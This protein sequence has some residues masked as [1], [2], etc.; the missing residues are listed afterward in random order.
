MKQN[1]K[2]I[3][4]LG[5]LLLAV[6]VC[7]AVLAVLA[8]TT[9]EADRRL[10]ERNREVTVETYAQ[11]REAQLWL[12]EADGQMKS[13]TALAAL[14]GTQTQDGITLKV[15]QDGENG[16]FVIGLTDDGAGSY[17]IVLWKPVTD[18]TPNTEIGTLWAGEGDSYEN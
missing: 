9:A 18:W 15:L 10:A 11:E 14:P 2:Q 13:G 5:V 8:L 3:G 12:S 4:I 16:A 6:T 17:R 7:L 1:T